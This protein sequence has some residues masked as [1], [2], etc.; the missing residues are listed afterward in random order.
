MSD[1][2]VCLC[3]IIHM[4]KYLKIRLSWVKGLF[5]CMVLK[6]IYALQILPLKISSIH[7]KDSFACLILKYIYILYDLTPNNQVRLD[8]R[9]IYTYGFEVRLCTSNLTTEN[10]LQSR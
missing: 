7:A 9:I 5:M 6:C 8:S 3:S 10:Q 1:F 4:T 2:E